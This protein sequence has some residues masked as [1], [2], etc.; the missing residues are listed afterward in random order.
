[1]LSTNLGTQK[2]KRR[3][4]WHLSHF[5]VVCLLRRVEGNHTP[6]KQCLGELNYNTNQNYNTGLLLLVLNVK[7]T[8]PITYRL[9]KQ[10]VHFAIIL[11]H[12]QS[13]LTTLPTF[14]TTS[15]PTTN[16][17]LQTF[18]QRLSSSTH[19][20][21]C[22]NQDNGDIWKNAGYEMKVSAPFRF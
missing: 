5:L 7:F 19:T 1:M 22:A 21:K 18:S 9:K 20:K 4:W 3:V 10:M 14:W 2:S 16:L 6:E 8:A 11:I 12:S 17:F 13:S 15:F